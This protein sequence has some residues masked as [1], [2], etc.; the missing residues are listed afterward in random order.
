MYVAHGQ[1]QLKANTRPA[2][3]V[4]TD[5]RPPLIAARISRM[6]A[7]AQYDIFRKHESELVWIEAALDLTS[8]KKR[9]QELAEQSGEK[10]VVYDHRARRIVA[11]HE[12][13]D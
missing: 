1:K 13:S 3:G 8:A 12:W 2:I 5:W 4:L 7:S 6:I 9:I 10:Y 11:G